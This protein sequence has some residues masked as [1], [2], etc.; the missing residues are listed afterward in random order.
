MPNLIK[1]L[2]AK[3][4][5]IPVGVKASLWFLICQFI[6]KAISVISTPIFTRLLSTSDYGQI[7]VFNS[8][9]SIISVFVSMNLFSG[10]YIQGLIKNEDKQAEYSSSLQGLCTTLIV[11]WFVLYLLFRNFWNRF[12]SLT[13]IQ[14]TALFVIIWASSTFSFWAVEQRVKLNYKRL[15]ALTLFVAVFNP[16][17][18]IILVVNCHDKVTAKILGLGIVELVAYLGCFISQMRRG[19]RFFS[20]EFW[21]HAIRFNIPLIPHYL[22]MSVLSGADRIMIEKLVNSSSAGIYS[23]AHSVSLIMSL[24]NVALLQAI[25]PWLYR[26]IK[27]NLICNLKNVGYPAFVVIAS[28]NI[29]LIALAPEVIAVFAPASYQEGIW[30][31]PPVAMSVFFMFLYTF[32]AVFEFY[33]EKTK[34][35][36]LATGGGAILNIILNYIFIR[37]FGYYAAAYTTLFCYIMYALFHY[38]AMAWICRNKHWSVPYNFYVLLCIA[39]LLMAL[40]F[41][42]MA[43]YNFPVIR[44]ALLL[45]LGILLVFCRKIISRYINLF[46]QLKKA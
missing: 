1:T 17:L 45:V 10:V 35:I 9:L 6:Q 22:A 2:Q 3:Y 39:F 7:S 4:Q 26:Q 37:R 27:N 23:L 14:V 12:L 25:E 11:S 40:G 38:L 19:K 15:V 34:L 36:A 29:I 18:G 20:S 42:F 21:I 8:W 33:F 16:L 28:I 24:F 43:V 32:F 31:I 5:C 13:T 44:F 30:L 46:L 41:G